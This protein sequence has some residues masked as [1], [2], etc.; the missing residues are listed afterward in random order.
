[1]QST[2][3][4]A[5][6]G[7]AIL[8]FSGSVFSFDLGGLVNKLQETTQTQ[9]N[10]NTNQEVQPTQQ[11]DQAAVDKAAAD[12]AN[13]DRV[14]AEKVAADKAAAE[15]AIAD[16]IAADKAAADQVIADKAA[17]DKAVDEAASDAL[18]KK[19]FIFG[20]IYTVILS[21]ILLVFFN[22]SVR[23]S[24]PNGNGNFAVRNLSSAWP[25]ALLVPICLGLSVFILSFAFL[26]VGELFG[27]QVLS[28][29]NPEDAHLTLYLTIGFFGG[30]LVASGLAMLFAKTF[31]I[32]EAGVAYD[33]ERKTIELPASGVEAD[34]LVDYVKPSY[35]FRFLRRD[36][37]PV[38]TIRSLTGGSTTTTTKEY[39]EVLK[40]YVTKI[41]TI[42]TL[43]IISTLGQWSIDFGSQQ[44]ADGARTLISEVANLS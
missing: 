44:K 34:S 4:N 35:L 36:H 18:I 26:G 23:K 27:K 3:R 13:L 19:E 10:T 37:I 11:I 28:V 14:I 12:Q 6:F 24:V 30:F 5:V 29:P 25:F 8:F 20:S 7:A 33:A 41:D 16:K 22:T 21:I 15:K 9:P 43:N 42:H 2:I 32:A 39:S 31:A 17:A 38:D 1:M 40:K